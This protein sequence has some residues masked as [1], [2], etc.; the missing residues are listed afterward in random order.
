MVNLRD[1][2]V[3]H[4]VMN[5]DGWSLF[6]A[7][8]VSADGRTIVGYGVN[9]LQTEAWIATI[10]EPSSVVLGAIAFFSLLALAW[11]GRRLA[12]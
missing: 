12:N 10:P 11:R 5:L 2:L 1:H 9:A 4:G 3:A 8:G 6:R 7:Y